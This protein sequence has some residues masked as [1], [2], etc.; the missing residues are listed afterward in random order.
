MKI[1]YK[2]LK[3]PKD[4]IHII[5]EY[6]TPIECCIC[7]SNTYE[8]CYYR[9]CCICQNLVIQNT[10]NNC[11]SKH[12]L[13]ICDYELQHLCQSLEHNCICNYELILHRVP[14]QLCRNMYCKNSYHACVII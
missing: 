8:C 12:H 2:S 9:H 4:L 3:L 7:I 6:Y 11:K 13:C 5:L 1:I 10:Y 14:P